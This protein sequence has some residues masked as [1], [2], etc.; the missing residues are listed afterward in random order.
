LSSPTQLNHTA[1]PIRLKHVT[2]VK[3]HETLFGI[4]RQS[5]QTSAETHVKRISLTPPNTSKGTEA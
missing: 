1:L 2:A 4:Y 5:G 3:W